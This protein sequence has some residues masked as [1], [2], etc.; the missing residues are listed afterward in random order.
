MISPRTKTKWL[1]YWQKHLGDHQSRL[2]NPEA[3]RTI[4]PDISKEMAAARIIDAIEKLKMDEIAN[5]AYW[6]AVETLIDCEPA[7]TTAGFYDLV[8]RQGGPT[9]GKICTMIYYPDATE[10]K[11]GP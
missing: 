2:D 1:A 10:E 8:P 5:A 4:C 3:H 11:L 6:N 7:F 9:L